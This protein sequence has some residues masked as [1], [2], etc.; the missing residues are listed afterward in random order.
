MTQAEDALLVAVI[1]KG[2]GGL[3]T[4]AA[5][6]QGASKKLFVVPDLGWHRLPSG[7]W[8]WMRQRGDSIRYGAKDVPT[9]VFTPPLGLSGRTWQT[10]WLEGGEVTFGFYGQDSTPPSEIWRF[11]RSGPKTALPEDARRALEEAW[12][13]MP[14][15]EQE[16]WQA[17]GSDPEISGFYRS[18]GAFMAGLQLPRKGDGAKLVPGRAGGGRTYL[19]SAKLSGL[20]PQAWRT[21]KST[22]GLVYDAMASDRTGWGLILAQSEVRLAPVNG[23]QFGRV[24]KRLTTEG[25][26]FTSFQ[27]WV[28]DEARAVFDELKRQ[29]P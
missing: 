22:G 26:R 7:Q 29:R 19:L 2:D 27:S 6:I 24:E 16:E 10:A 3:S 8:L 14:S 17:P 11:S 18:S 15:R 21:A 12:Q 9:E 1:A 25:V 4:V 20:S 23:G 5:S 28:G 13:K